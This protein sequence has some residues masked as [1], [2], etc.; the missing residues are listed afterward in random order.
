M[1]DRPPPQPV[2]V[3]VCGSPDRGDDAAAIIAVEELPEA[4]RELAEI[5]VCGAL[6]VEDLADVPDGGACLVLDA[7]VGVPPGEIIDG[8]IASL[9]DRARSAGPAPHSSHV[10]PIGEILGLARAV[11]GSLPRG[12]FLGLGSSSFGIGDPLSPA[13]A[14][15]LPGFRAAIA[16]EIER[17]SGQLDR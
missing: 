15:A 9:A 5:V 1:T 4:V 6:G 10:L 13:V 16:A 2:R 14:A 8:S 17:L 11:R 3:F 12:A 7:A